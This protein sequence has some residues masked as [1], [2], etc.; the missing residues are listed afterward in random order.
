MFSV[1]ETE[2]RGLRGRL[3]TEV[4]HV[5]VPDVFEVLRIA[6]KKF[7]CD[8]CG[9]SAVSPDELEM[10]GLVVVVAA[11]VIVER[12]ANRILIGG[13][14]KEAEISYRDECERYSRRRND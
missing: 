11:A 3:H 1:A 10:L 4:V 8:L 9:V 12:V 6:L 14:R 5:D 13:V 2:I 7:V